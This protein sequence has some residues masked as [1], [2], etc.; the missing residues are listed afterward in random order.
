VNNSQLMSA[1][2]QVVLKQQHGD[3]ARAQQ[4]MK[5][6][7]KLPPE[8]IRHVIQE[9]KKRVEQHKQQGTPKGATLVGYRSASVNKAVALIVDMYSEG[10]V[11]EARILREL[12]ATDDAALKKKIEDLL[13]SAITEIEWKESAEKQDWKSWEFLLKSM[14]PKPTPEELKQQ[15]KQ[16]AKQNVHEISTN[17]LKEKKKQEPKVNIE[18]FEDL[19]RLNTKRV[20]S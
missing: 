5:L 19:E 8:S 7:G 4:L 17:L 3:K 10:H 14:K 9:S 2:F 13:I 15:E 11:R 18:N 20:E 1:L 16:K 12:L 6:F